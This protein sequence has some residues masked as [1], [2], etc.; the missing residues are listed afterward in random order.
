MRDTCVDVYT[1]AKGIY[2]STVDNKFECLIP[3]HLRN[4]SSDKSF[5][6]SKLPV[7]V[8]NGAGM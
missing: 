5:N 1:V 4:K 7:S 2:C 3:M 6:L 8:G